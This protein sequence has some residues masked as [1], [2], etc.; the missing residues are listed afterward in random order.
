MKKIL[1]GLLLAVLVVTV[2]VLLRTW[3]FKAPVTSVAAV[4]LV[5][6]STGS[7]SRLAEAVKI[8]TLSSRLLQPNGTEPFLAFHQFLENS[9]PLVHQHLQREI[10][11]DYSLLFT[12]EGSEPELAPILLL[13]HMDVVP[14]EPGTEYD[15]QFPAFAGVVAN[16]YLWGRG[17]WDDKSTLLASLEAIELMLEQGLKPQRTVMLAFGHDEEVSGLQGAVKIAEMLSQRNVRFE[18]VLDEGASIDEGRFGIEGAVA[19]VS[20]AEKGYLTLQ[21]TA[22]GPGGH[23][24]MPPAMTAVGRLAQAVD[25]LQKQTMPASLNEPTIAMFEALA[26][27]LP[28]VP[29]LMW[30]NRWLFEPVIVQALTKDS[31]SAALVRTTTA[32]TMLSAG[33][34]ENVLPQSAQATVNFRLAPGDSRELVVA[35]GQ[36]IIDDNEVQVTVATGLQSEPSGVASTDSYGYQQISRAVQEVVPEARVVPFLLFGATDSRHYQALSDSIFKF[37]AIQLAAGESNNIHGTNEKVPVAGYLGLIQF[38]HRLLLNS[39][40]ELG[41]GQ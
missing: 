31:I 33:V 14:V 41:V 25:R 26:N 30:A 18:F 40:V 17:A 10:V 24:S 37:S 35:R 34:K 36:A 7:V 9:F 2:V 11:N 27:D 3:Q 20:V 8:P 16:G 12:W 15:W 23:S 39:A 21:L 28:F 4:K 5:T 38:Y 29:K 32:P 19:L 1:C 22:S 13:S 6:P